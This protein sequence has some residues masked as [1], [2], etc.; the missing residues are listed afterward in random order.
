MNLETLDWDDE[1]LGC[2][3][4]PKSMLPAIK[5][6]SE[7]YGTAVG[8]LDG[9]PDRRRPRRPAGGPVRPD[10]LRR[11]RGEEHLRHRLLHAPQHGHQGRAVEERPA[12][13]ARL[14][15][16]RPARGLR[17][18]GLDRDHRR[19]RPVAARQPRADHVVGRG[20]GAGRDRRGQRRRLLRAG[21]LRPVRAVLEERRPWRH[22]RPHP[23]RQQG[24]H[25]TGHARGDRLADPRGARRDERRLRRRA[26]GPQGRRRHGLQRA[27]HA[28]PVRRPR[29]AGH[30]AEGRRD[31]GPRGGLRG[32]PGGRLLERPWRTSAQNWAKDKEWTPKMD[33]GPARQGVRASGRR[34]SP[35]PSTGSRH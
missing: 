2:M 12:D 15:D 8:D 30:P 4:I 22:R 13:D 32:R 25:R 3:G 34:P 16:R 23:L 33:A 6:S 17:A 24:P 35:G 10:V 18:R 26:D 31:D 9:H 1:I 14:Q 21:V 29:R 28:V 5:A 27:A 7:V 19:A 11:R 20:R